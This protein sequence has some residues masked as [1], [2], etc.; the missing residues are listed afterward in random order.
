M[1][2]PTDPG[3]PAT[4]TPSGS[5]IVPAATDAAVAALVDVIK[6][7]I[8]P[9]AVQA[10]QIMLRRLALE[11]DVIP[12]RL[13]APRNITEVGGYLNLVASL[14]QP[15]LQ[16]QMLAGALGVA[17]PAVPAGWVMSTPPLTFVTLAADRPAGPAQP[18]FPLNLSLRSDFASAVSMAL[19]ALHRS[20]AGLPLSGALTALPAP[21]AAA[22]ADLLRCLGRVLLIPATAAMN[23]PT[24]DPISLA[25]SGDSPELQL[26]A[27]AS[28]SAPAGTWHALV[29]DRTTDT[30]SEVAVP[31]STRL[32][33]IAPVLAEAGFYPAVPL[34]R[35]TRPADSAWAR[36]TN[37]TG[38]VAG[39]TRLGDELSQLY[40]SIDIG[41]SGLA[42]KLHWTWDGTAFAAP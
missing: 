18:T 3:A 21:D 19:D 2:T 40:R 1:T 22:G 13:P 29:T 31:D 15:E 24:S 8:S 30:V 42:D 28:A 25:R 39:Q 34:P 37:V 17:G 33:P 5:A 27:R 4:G 26:V 6:S 23:D 14:Q 38:L 9:D 10:Q 20:G 11:G 16:A 32:V 41:V 36:L 12:S 7:S 35:P